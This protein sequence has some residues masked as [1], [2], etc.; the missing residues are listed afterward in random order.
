MRYLSDRRPKI[1]GALTAFHITPLQSHEMPVLSATSKEDLLALPNAPLSS[2][3]PEELVRFAQIVDTALFKSYL[4]NR[5]GLLGPL[6]RVGWCEV[7][8]VEELLREREVATAL[9]GRVSM[10]LTTSCAEISGD[11]PLVPRAEDARK[12]VGPPPTVSARLCFPYP[13][14]H[15]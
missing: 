6:C 2:L 14:F 4:L 1:A 10:T 12:G 13:T 7:S 5:P 8:E 15:S 11:D 9:P 3:T